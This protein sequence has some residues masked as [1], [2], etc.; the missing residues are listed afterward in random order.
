M[1][2]SRNCPN[3]AWDGMPKISNIVRGRGGLSPQAGRGRSFASVAGDERAVVVLQ[4]TERLVGRDGRAQLEEVA[5]IL[6]FFGRLDLE[7]IGRVGHPA[8]DADRAVAE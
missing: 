2:P 3:S 1:S 8:V 7:Q 5:R 4:R 6:G